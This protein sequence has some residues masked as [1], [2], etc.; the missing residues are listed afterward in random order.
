MGKHSCLMWLQLC[1]R[2]ATRHELVLFFRTSCNFE[3]HSEFFLFIVLLINSLEQKKMVLWFLRVIFMH[4][5]KS[6]FNHCN[7]TK[8]LFLKK[9][10]FKDIFHCLP[11]NLYNLYPTELLLFFWKN[12]SHVKRSLK[13][14]SIYIYIYTHTQII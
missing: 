11:G 6:A 1:D 7:F 10:I 4:S 8:I 2:Y 14:L 3:L 5:Y 9:K 12:W 13:Y